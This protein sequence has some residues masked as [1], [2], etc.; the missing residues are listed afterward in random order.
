VAADARRCATSVESKKTLGCG[1]ATSAIVAA[2]AIKK[3]S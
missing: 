3:P 1:A 2:S